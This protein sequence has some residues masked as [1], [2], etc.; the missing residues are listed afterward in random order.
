MMGG[1]LLLDVCEG[2]GAASRVEPEKVGRR[3]LA[4]HGGRRPLR[5]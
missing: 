1:P 2:E 4:W 3:Y 5:G